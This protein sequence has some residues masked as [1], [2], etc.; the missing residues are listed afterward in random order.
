MIFDDQCT[1]NDDADHHHC[2]PSPYSISFYSVDLIKDRTMFSWGEAG[3]GETGNPL[4]MQKRLDGPE[5]DF[6]YFGMDH[7]SSFLG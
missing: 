4:G 5:R 6:D 1:E 7:R 3:F 2:I